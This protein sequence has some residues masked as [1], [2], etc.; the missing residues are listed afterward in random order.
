[1]GY[2]VNADSKETSEETSPTIT[3]THDDDMLF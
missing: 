2:T 1:M 3:N